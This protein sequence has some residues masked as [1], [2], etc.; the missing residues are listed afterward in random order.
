MEDW[1]DVLR[2]FFSADP[3]EQGIG[4]V[5]LRRLIRRCL[6]AQVAVLGA[7]T[8][9]FVHERL[10]D[11]AAAHHAGELQ[12]R[13]LPGFVKRL[14]AWR[15]TDW[16]RRARREVPVAEDPRGGDA[17]LGAD[18]EMRLR[19][20]E[21]LAQLPAEQWQVFRLNRLEGL[22]LDATAARLGMSRGMVVGRLTK[23]LA[24]LAELLADGEKSFSREE[25]GRS[26]AYS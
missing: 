4:Y 22:T 9:D 7:E 15:F 2:R 10:I 24:L 6:G 13:T 23:A 18:P 17:D 3:V 21:V 25:D 14:V 1:A 20:R 5:S 16:A 19:L 12:P 8:E 11:I 26:R